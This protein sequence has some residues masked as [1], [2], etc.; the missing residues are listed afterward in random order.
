MGKVLAP[1]LSGARMPAT[2]VFEHDL[3]VVSNDPAN[4][5]RSGPPP[6]C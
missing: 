4:G 1:P 2:G 6:N 5:L 3:A